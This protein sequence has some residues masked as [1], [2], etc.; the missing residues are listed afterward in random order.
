MFLRL[1]TLFWRL[2]YCVVL[3]IREIKLKKK[4]ALLSQRQL[5][6]GAPNC[7]V[8]H[9]AVS[10]APGRRLSTGCS[11]EAINGVRL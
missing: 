7:P 11:R 1:S 8:V 10:D 9:R 6:L 2:M 4:M 3:E 5:G